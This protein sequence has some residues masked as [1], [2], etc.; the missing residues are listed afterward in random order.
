MSKDESLLCS[1]HIFY[2]L[3]GKMER[4]ISLDDNFSCPDVNFQ[5]EKIN[6]LL[7]VVVSLHC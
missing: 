6:F 3:Y 2:L 4:E 7:E 1:S 5:G